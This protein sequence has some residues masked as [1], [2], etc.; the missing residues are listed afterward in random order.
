MKT[1]EVKS[2]GGVV[3]NREGKI[4]VVNQRGSS[5]SLPKGHVEPGEDALNAAKREILEESGIKNLILIKQ[6]PSYERFRIGKDGGD[7]RSELKQISM[8]LFRT[9]ETALAPTDPGN[10]EAR[11]VDKSEVSSMLTHDKDR[12]FFNKILFELENLTNE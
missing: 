7:D 3:V 5:W 8:F 12:E 4:L 11:F 2:A 1:R 10:P 9:D 6:L